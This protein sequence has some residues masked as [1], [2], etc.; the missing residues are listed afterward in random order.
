MRAILLPLVALIGLAACSSNTVTSTGSTTTGTTT[1]GTGGSTT[2][3]TG[4]GGSTTA[5][6]GPPPF[7]AGSPITAPD[8]AWTW[9]P[10]DNAFCGNGTSVGIGVNLS[11]TSSRVLL[12]LEGGGACWS[13]LTCSA[14]VDVAMDFT[15]GYTE[16]DFT[17]ESTDTTYL[18]EPDGFFDRTSA[19][20]PFKDYSYVYVPYCTGD[21]HA[22]DNVVT[23]TGG[24]GHHVGF[25][26]MTA[27]LE[28]I[29]PTFPTADRV[30]LAG[31]S[32]GGFGAAFNWWQTQKAFGS[33][34]VDLIDDSGTPMPPDIEADGSGFGFDANGAGETVLR[35]QWGL[36]KTFP[37]GCTGCATRLDAL[38]P[39]YATAFPNQKATLLSYIDDA[40]LPTFYGITTAQFVT[41]LNEEL[42]DDFTAKDVNFQYFTVNAS[43]HVLL[44]TPS[45]T[46]STTN[47]TTLQTFITQMVTDDPAWTSQ[48]P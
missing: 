9:V 30:I 22:G 16:A 35:T 38:L 11:T 39:F 45:L 2:T 47:T 37:P 33:I 15:T 1:S 19:S 31:S 26:N 36:A 8:S 44:F 48:H 40:V 46:P 14:A 3:T 18:A 4:T 17:A 32:A 5:D 41:G 20:N 29:V 7:T 42:A 6:G 13:D 27:F 21:I 23:Y 10:F 28:R 24:T 25:A 43:G 34:R 12:Y